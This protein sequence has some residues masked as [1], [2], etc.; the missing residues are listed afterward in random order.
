M[1]LMPRSRRRAWLRDEL[2]LA[3]DLFQREGPNPPRTSIQALSAT[4]RSIPVEPWLASD[5]AFRSEA[6][7]TR[8]IGNF[9]ALATGGQAGLTHGGRILEPQVWESFH[10]DPARLQQAAEAIRANLGTLAPDALSDPEDSGV[11]EAPEGNLLTRIHVVRERSRK[12]VEAK[13]RA[14]IAQTGRLA[15]E[16]CGFEFEVRYGPPGAGFIECHHKTPVSKLRPGDVT[17]LADLAVV[18]AN[19]HRIIHKSAPWRSVEEV[20]ALVGRG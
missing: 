16:C 9:Q 8:K 20:A 5:P 4:L 10:G 17:R 3:L 2:I 7:A 13:K 14:V 1:T 12:L 11:T 19:C 15:C 18:C 6:S